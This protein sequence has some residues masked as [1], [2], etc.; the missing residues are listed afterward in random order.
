[1]TLTKGR[2]P[3]YELNALAGYA[4]G[5]AFRVSGRNQSCNIDFS[6]GDGASLL[7]KCIRSAQSKMRRFVEIRVPSRSR[8]IVEFIPDTDLESAGSTEHDRL[9]TVGG[10]L[11]GA[12]WNQEDFSDWDAKDG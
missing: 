10:V 5:D 4:R 2:T 11:A 12:V 1:L 9:A 6:G 8:D 7:A 3:K